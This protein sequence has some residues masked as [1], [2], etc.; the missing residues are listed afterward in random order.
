MSLLTPK[1]SWMTR[2]PGPLPLAGLAR[3]PENSPSGT[4]IVMS[5]MGAPF[6]DVSDGSLGARSRQAIPRLDYCHPAARPRPWQPPIDSRAAARLEEHT[7]ELQS[8]MR[9]PYAVL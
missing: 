7:Y 8:L 5:G 1:I 4:L 2:M 6:V 9:I 3:Y